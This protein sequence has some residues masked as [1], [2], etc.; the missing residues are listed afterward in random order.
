MSKNEVTL[1]NIKFIFARITGMNK[2]NRNK[3]V[4]VRLSEVPETML[5][6][7]HNRVH[8]AKRSD[9]WI[10]DPK[11]LEIY[12]LIDYEFERSFGPSEPSHA[13]R[14][15][16]FDK[17]ILEFWNDYPEGTVINL[18]EGLETQRFRLAEKRS[19]NALWVTVDLPNAIE[20][21]EKFISSDN[22]NLHIAA[23]ALEVDLWSTQVP[24]DK[25]V[26]ITAQGLFMYFEEKDVRLL[27]QAISQKFPG[28]TMWFDSISKWFS[29]KTL[30]GFQKTK[31]YTIPKMPFGVN[32]F[33][34]IDL[35][36][37]WVPGLDIQEM[38]WPTDKVEGI[39]R[40]LIPIFS[41]IPYVRGLQPGCVFRAKFPEK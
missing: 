12:G 26:L 39:W 13:I 23:S 16:I 41:K 3:R 40:Y 6:T 20:V 2:K 11:A 8:V 34:A 32:K 29:N 37:G 19:P 36:T 21:R 5:W 9:G 27:F 18:G 24:V 7:L 14:S 1:V 10:K 38:N 30:R 28:C 22:N 25:P 31:H 35:F 4:Q 33:D 15:L 17:A